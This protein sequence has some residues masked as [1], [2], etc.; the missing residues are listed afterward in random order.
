MTSRIGRL[1]DPLGVL[2]LVN[3]FI[4]SFLQA[5]RTATAQS[6]MTV[7]VHCPCGTSWS[8]PPFLHYGGSAV[9][10]KRCPSCGVTG[11][12]TLSATG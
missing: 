9:N 3:A 4:D 8:Y 2:D 10:D 7:T 1:F 12:T 11:T 5:Y 6:D